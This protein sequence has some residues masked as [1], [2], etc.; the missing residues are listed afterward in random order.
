MGS[1]I[2]ETN[3][4]APASNAAFSPN[5]SLILVLVLV[6]LML[7]N[8]FQLFGITGSLATLS[9]APATTSGT[10]SSAGT[11]TGTTSG[12]SS[13]FSLPTGVPAIYGSELGV[14]YDD[15][16]ASNPT[17]SNAAIGKMKALDTSITLTGANL[18]RY[19]TVASQ[20]SCEYCCGA[21]SIISSTGA[22][23]CGCAHSYAMRGLAKY[24]ILNHGSEFSDDEILSELAKWKALYFPSQMQ[25]KAAI[26]ADQGIPTTFI[27][28]GSNKYTG[29]ESGSSGS[30]MVGGC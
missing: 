15:V 19:I 24:L 22:A 16:T 17:T 10:T 23:A 13:G 8:S 14:S 4:E 27:N 2:K 29:I 3:S 18:Q 7:F 26:L 25:S 11:T 20:I 5:T 12:T 21:P 28:V 1:D 30:G 9:A 6:G